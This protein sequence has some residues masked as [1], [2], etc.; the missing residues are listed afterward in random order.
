MLLGL[1]FSSVIVKEVGAKCRATGGFG[2]V[3]SALILS[4]RDYLLLKSLD[5]SICSGNVRPLGLLQLVILGSE[6]AASRRTKNQV[7]LEILD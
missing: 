6:G 5:T 4:S 7:S 1:R 3:V 2:E